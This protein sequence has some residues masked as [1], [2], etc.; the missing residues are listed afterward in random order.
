MRYSETPVNPQ[1][2][3]YDSFILRKALA[4]TLVKTDPEAWTWTTQSK[5]KPSLR[6]T[7]WSVMAAHNTSDAVSPNEEVDRLMFP[8][9]TLV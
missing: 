5:L 4:N 3:R 8:Q 6:G 9:Y 7:L 2:H 1:T